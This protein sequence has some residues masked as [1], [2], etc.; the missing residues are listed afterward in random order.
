[1]AART[2]YAPVSYRRLPLWKA[3]LIAAA[4]AAVVNIAIYYAGLPAGAFPRDVLVPN[5]NQPFT[6]FPILT[7]S[8]IGV[9]MGLLL[10]ALIRRFSRKPLRIFIPLAVVVGLLSFYLPFT[11]PGAPLLMVLLLN[12]MHVVAAAATLWAAAKAV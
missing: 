9:T 10:F 4:A 2:T 11:I 3:G 8:L 6:I 5:A 7:A 12:L 1:M